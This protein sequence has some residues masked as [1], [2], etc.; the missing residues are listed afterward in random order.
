MDRTERTTSSYIIRG[1]VCLFVL[2]VSQPS[3][4]EAININ[5]HHFLENFSAG[6]P[7]E[8]ISF[9]LWGKGI[10]GSQPK[11]KPT[12]HDKVRSNGQISDFPT[13]I[14]LKLSRSILEKGYPPENYHGY[15]K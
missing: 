10:P 15:P 5:I 11:P 14:M 4:E 13:K 1:L 8:N 7:Y 6:I 2:C 12:D 3:F 9:C